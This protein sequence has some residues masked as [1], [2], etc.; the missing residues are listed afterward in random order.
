MCEVTLSIC[1]V[2]HK[3]PGAGKRGPPEEGTHLQNDF[4]SGNFA[5]WR[6]GEDLPGLRMLGDLPQ[7]LA[8]R[9]RAG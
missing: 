1:A 9:S 4:L 6:S 8:L 3:G 2:L 5:P 7:G